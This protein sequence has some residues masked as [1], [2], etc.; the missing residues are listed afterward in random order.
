M[1]DPKK[2]VPEQ[3]QKT[4]TLTAIQDQE[5]T[6]AISRRAK[7]EEDYNT[8]KNTEDSIMRMILDANKI[9][10]SKFIGANKELNKFHVFLTK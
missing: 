7:A 5:M 6:A 3:I 2:K 8:A 1:A 9:D 4:L 10:Q